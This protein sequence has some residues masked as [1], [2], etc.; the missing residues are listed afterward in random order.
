[1][2]DP[3]NTGRG[4]NVCIDY[5]TVPNVTINTFIESDLLRPNGKI[6]PVDYESNRQDIVNF[7]TLF[8]A[9]A[10]E[11]KDALVE[12]G[13]L[14]QEII[15]NPDLDPDQKAAL[16][17]QI[18]TDVFIILLS[19]KDIYEKFNIAYYY[20]Y[21]SSNQP[22]YWKIYNPKIEL[23]YQNSNLKRTVQ[24]LDYLGNPVNDDFTQLKDCICNCDKTEYSPP[25]VV[26]PVVPPTMVSTN[27]I[28]PFLIVL[29]IF[30]AIVVILAII[31]I[32]ISAMSPD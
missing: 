28:S 15:N 26:T 7:Y 1:M 24:G 4:L 32:I 27:S 30:I 2:V 13:K 21:N 23:L 3:T 11:I 16:I 14:I 22:Q 31:L 17:R 10:T 12:S 18:L 29:L 20:G 19:L 25:I 6:V 9:Q 5:A 8:L